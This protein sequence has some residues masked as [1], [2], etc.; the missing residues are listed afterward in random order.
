[1]HLAVLRAGG[2]GGVRATARAATARTPVPHVGVSLRAAGVSRRRAVPA[3]QL[4]RAGDREL[5]GGYRY[6]LDGCAGVSVARAARA[7]P[8]LARNIRSLA[9]RSGR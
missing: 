9:R 7:P 5:R 8:A 4:S 2:S 1:R 6:H 3:R